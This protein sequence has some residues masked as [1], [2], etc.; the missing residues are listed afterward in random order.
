MT[1]NDVV[2][3]VEWALLMAQ[4]PTRDCTPVGVLLL[5]AT[6][7]ELHIKL[8]P[9][10]TGVHEEV[11]EFWRELP[12]DLIE[13]SGAVG[14]SR[15]LD[16]LET[17]A[18]HVIQLGSRARMDTTNPQETLDLLYRQYVTGDLEIQRPA[19]REFQRGAGG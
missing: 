10:L 5:D 3:T 6:S 17:T 9:E 11:T 1:Y 7:D 14:G 8:L 18:S 19:E 2:R 16:W 13:R 4:L 12:S 15:V